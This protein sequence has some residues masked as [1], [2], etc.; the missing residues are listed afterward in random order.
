MAQQED[1]GSPEKKALKEARM[2]AKRL[3]Y[4]RMRP[5]LQEAFRTFKHILLEQDSRELHRFSAMIEWGVRLLGEDVLLDCFAVSRATLRCWVSG[6]I[7]PAP[8]ARA[9]ILERME[10]LVDEDQITSI[11]YVIYVRDF[12]LH[13]IV[14]WLYGTMLEPTYKH[15]RVYRDRE[16]SYAS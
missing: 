2:A 13:T 8:M 10:R 12:F 7:T 15:A 14:S 6:E 11:A 1:S 5:A 16:N 4:T 3:I 9:S